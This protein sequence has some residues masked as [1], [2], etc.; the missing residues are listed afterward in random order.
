MLSRMNG[1]Q[2]MAQILREERFGKEFAG[3]RRVS[4]TA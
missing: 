3:T 4:F 2:R 1:K